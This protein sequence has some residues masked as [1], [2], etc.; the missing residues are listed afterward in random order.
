L[1]P[2]RPRFPPAGDYDVIW[3]ELEVVPS[4]RVHVV[5]LELGGLDG[6]FWAFDSFSWSCHIVGGWKGME[7]GPQKTNAQNRGVVREHN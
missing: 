3:S 1:G 5:V 6:P 4:C 7:R 2:C